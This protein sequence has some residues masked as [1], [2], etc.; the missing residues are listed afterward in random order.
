MT[1]D[2]AA[3]YESHSASTPPKTWSSPS[4]PGLHI[5]S[6]QTGGNRHA[7]IACRADAVSSENDLRRW[8]S[9][10]PRC[11]ENPQPAIM[12]PR[13]WTQIDKR[14]CSGGDFPGVV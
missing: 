2:G 13:R 3:G 9:R 6:E 1:S 12:I 14:C 7:L 5:S 8:K 4:P 11:G 10:A